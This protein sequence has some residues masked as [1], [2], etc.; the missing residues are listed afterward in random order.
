MERAEAWHLTCPLAGDT[1][2]IITISNDVSTIGPEGT[3]E[4]L[5]AFARRLE[6]EL[7]HY[8]DDDNIVVTLGSVFRTEVD[9]RDDVRE[10]VA[11]IE[12]GTE[13]CQVLLRACDGL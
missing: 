5:A 4:E 7:Q 9:G 3:T 1:M 12:G 13:W 8:F 2:T 10:R 11:E 6:I